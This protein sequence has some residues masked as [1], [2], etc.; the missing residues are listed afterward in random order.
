MEEAAALM[1]RAPACLLLATIPG[2]D[3][4]WGSLD[5]YAEAVRQVGR[6]HPNIALADV[7]RHFKG[8]GKEA[9]ADLMA[10][11]AHPNRTGQEHMARVV[12]EAITGDGDVQ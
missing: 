12:F 10:D 2:R 11:E 9:Y 7:N 8:L 1:D 6:E 4:H 5:V 3:K